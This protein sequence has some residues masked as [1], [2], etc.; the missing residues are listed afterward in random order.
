MGI[1]QIRLAIR[2]TLATDIIIYSCSKLVFSDWLGL[3]LFLH[4]TQDTHIRDGAD[5][6]QRILGFSG[7]PAGR[8]FGFRTIGYPVSRWG[9]N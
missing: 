5:I 2:L 1:A 7:N 4:C 6:R 3:H 9:P 8:I